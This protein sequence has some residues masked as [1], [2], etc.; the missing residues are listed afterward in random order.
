MRF[1]A[2]NDGASVGLSDTECSFSTCSSEG[3]PIL[4]M[5]VIASHAKMMGTENRW[6]VRATNGG[7]V[8]S[9]PM[10][11]VRRSCGLQQAGGKGVHFVRDLLGFDLTV[12]QDAAANAVTIALRHDTS[13]GR[14]R[15]DRELHRPRQ[16]RSS[17][18]CG[19]ALTSK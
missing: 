5:T 13:H 11:M 3:T 10:C 7:A 19:S 15:G 4:T 8:C 12:H 14:R 16:A 1:I 6:I 18:C 9:L 2:L 17:T